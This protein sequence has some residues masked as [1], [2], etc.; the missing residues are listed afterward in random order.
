MAKMK[1]IKVKNSAGVESIHDIAVDAANVEN[2]NFTAAEERA[3]INSGE[4]LPTLL[5]KF[6]KWYS[7]FATLV[8]TG[9]WKDLAD[10]PGIGDLSGTLAVTKGGTGA[11]TASQARTNLGVGASGT[12]SVANNCT[13]TTA[14]S[15]LDARQ[16]K[17]LMD[18]AN[19]ISSDL[20]GCQLS[21]QEDGAYITYTL[22]G[23]AD[24]VSRKLGEPTVIASGLVAT[25][26]RNIDCT[27]IAGY[28]NL[29]VDNFI[30]RATGLKSGTGS[31][32][33]FGINGSLEKTYNPD[34]GVLTVGKCFG[35]YYDYSGNNYGA[36]VVYDVLLA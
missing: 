26:A 10:K 9:S 7:S 3:D 6:K 33:S 4:S 27:A 13:T 17:V 30:L 36:A 16:G 35:K 23:G 31:N 28:Q 21:V 24:P 20:G 18:K 22:P 15:V 32:P 5:G 12:Q 1:Q 34:T 29:T 2:I 14:G 11:T 25:G 19:Q 8:W